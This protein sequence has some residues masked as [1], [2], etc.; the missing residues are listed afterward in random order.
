ME[1]LA[2]AFTR[3]ELS[4]VAYALYERFRPKITPGKGGWGQKG[5]LDLSLLRKMASEAPQAR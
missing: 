3:D 2:A 4:E 5:A 1:E